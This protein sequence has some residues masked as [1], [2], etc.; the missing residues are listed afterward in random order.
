MS[1]NGQPLSADDFKKKAADLG[2]PPGEAEKLFKDMDKDG[3]GI[4]S[5][6]EMQGA[7]GVDEDEM[8]DRMIDQFGNAEDAMKAAD[9]DGDGQ[10][11]KEEMEKMLQE[12]MG[13]TPENAKKL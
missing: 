5:E 13:I 11:S 12:K 1:P 8:Q 6:Q 4:V 7:V 2:I 9:A 10:V 3:D